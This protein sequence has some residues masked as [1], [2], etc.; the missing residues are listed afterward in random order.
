[1]QRT[2]PLWLYA[3]VGAFILLALVVRMPAWASSTPQELQQGTVPP[4]PPDDEEDDRNDNR[5][6][7]RNPSDPAPVAPAA[8]AVPVVAAAEV[9]ATATLTEGSPYTG[10]IIAERLNVR[11]GPGVTFTVLGRVFQ[12]Q[13]VRLRFRNEDASWWY[14]CCISGT[15]SSG[16]VSA[17]FVEPAFDPEQALELVPLAPLTGAL[18][19]AGAP[20]GTPGAKTGT[21]AT[22]RLNVRNSPSL[23]GTVVGQL[24]SG[25][26]VEIAA[27]NRA[28][29]WWLVCC[30]PESTTQGWV[31]S[32]FVSPSFPRA[33]AATVLPVNNGSP[34][35][36]PTTTPTPASPASSSAVEP[37]ATLTASETSAARPETALEVTVAQVPTLAVQG[38]PVQILYAIENAGAAPVT[39]IELRSELPAGILLGRGSASGGA[40][41]T[42]AKTAEGADLFAFLWPAI[43]PGGVI[44]AAVEISVSEALTDG[45]IIDSLAAISAENAPAQTATLSIGL[46]PATLPDFR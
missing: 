1:M 43:E 26:S 45:I 21:V 2:R 4:P 5:D 29:D 9:T 40:R 38:E 11:A 37:T 27:R 6:D 36:L 13:E 10:T 42:S 32:R 20:Q 35:A 23:S 14:T 7:D 3:I 28:G 39:A 12:D 15:E 18:G 41:F 16:W 25:D 8:P 19:A 34:A 30:V 22:L 33:S 46:P 17:L 44:T 24:N 31:A